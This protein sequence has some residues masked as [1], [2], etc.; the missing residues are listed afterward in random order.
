MKKI[1]LVVWSIALLCVGVLF[2]GGY[3]WHLMDE[4]Y[5]ALVS[6]VA[7][8][9]DSFY[10]E[11]HL[12]ALDALESGD[13]AKAKEIIAKISRSEAQSIQECKDNPTCSQ[14]VSKQLAANAT[15]ERAKNLP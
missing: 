3:G 8:A 13:V 4:R 10:L 15:L 12:A 7:P 1:V 9:N 2:G 11:K 14:L 6:T 5:G